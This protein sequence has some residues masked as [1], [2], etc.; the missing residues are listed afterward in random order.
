MDKERSPYW[1]RRDRDIFDD[2]F[3]DSWPQDRIGRHF[4][5]FDEFEEQF[6]RMQQRMNNLYR[7]TIKGD[8]GAPQEGRLKVYGWTYKVG[9]DGKP[10]FQEFGN[11]QRTPLSKHLMKKQERRYS[12]FI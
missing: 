2:F 4:D 5:I 9:S 11:I 3:G 6:K 8:F 1:R 7:G 12:R 10:V